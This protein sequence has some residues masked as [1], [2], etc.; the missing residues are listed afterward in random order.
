[1]RGKRNLLQGGDR[2]HQES[3]RVSIK[4]GIVLVTLFAALWTPSGAEAQ[5]ATSA[6]KAPAPSPTGWT[7]FVEVQY[8]FDSPL[9]NVIITDADLGYSLTDHLTVDVGVPVI[10]TRNPFSPVIDHDYYWSTLLGEPY[11]DA[12][13]SSTYKDLNYTSVLTAKIP[14]G[15]EDKTYVTG[16]VGVDWFNHVEDPMGKLTPFI[17]FGASN[18]T[19]NQ[20]IIP[21]PFNEARPYETLGLMGDAEAGAD[22]KIDWHRIHDVKIGASYYALIPGGPQKVFSRLVF[23][24]SVLGGDGQHHRYFDSTFETTVGPYGTSA[25]VGG[26]YGVSVNGISSIDRDNGYSGWLD[27]T[28]WHPVDVQ[29]GYT[30]SVHYLLNV[31]TVN[32]TFD[33]QNFVR[34]LL[35]RRH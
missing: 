30:R 35:T 15:N 33:A 10:W 13:Y 4:A 19:I 22:Y 31:Y 8:G 28:R 16:R 3:A 14:V 9:G 7:G 24:Y 26:V 17:N 23:P 25:I 2:C 18:G 1:M 5:T 12:R 21:R 29:I 32:I 6:T 27:I 11:L 34:S 20:F